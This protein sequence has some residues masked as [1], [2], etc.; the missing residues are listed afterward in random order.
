MKRSL[1][2]RI[3]VGVIVVAAILAIGSCSIPG[4]SYIRIV[5]SPSSSYTIAHV[6]IVNHGSSTWGSDWLAPSVI[7]PGNAVDFQV[8]PGSFDVDVT[9]TGVTPFDS[10]AYSVQVFSGNRTTLYYNGS[11]L[12]Q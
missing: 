4:A 7:T 12:T 1:R 2:R 10:F 3:V 5:N 6:Y 9:D 8:N 11:T